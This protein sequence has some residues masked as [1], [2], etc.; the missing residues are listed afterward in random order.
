MTMCMALT[1]LA[2]LINKT[3]QWHEAC[4][5]TGKL[6]LNDQFLFVVKSV[7][8]CL[9]REHFSFAASNHHKTILQGLQTFF[10]EYICF[11]PTVN[12]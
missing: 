10:F 8:S 9:Y 12:R 11:M 5:Q 7:S 2:Y 6:V 1:R 3:G 4:R